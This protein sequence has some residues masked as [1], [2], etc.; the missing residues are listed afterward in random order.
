MPQHSNPELEQYESIWHEALRFVCEQQGADY[1]YFEGS[2]LLRSNIQPEHVVIDGYPQGWRQHYLDN[3]YA[4]IDPAVAHTQSHLSPFVWPTEVD[5]FARLSRAQKKMYADAKNFGIESGIS[6]TYR[7]VSAQHGTLH[8]ASEQ[9][10]AKSPLSD[11]AV[12]YEF[13]MLGTMLM[14]SHLEQHG[15][16]IAEL[17]KSLTPRETECLRWVAEG[18]TSEE[19]ADIIGISQRT[20]VFHLQNAMEK[21]GTHSRTSAA[22]KY[23]LYSIEK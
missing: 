11:K 16:A 10:L 23:A 8:I 1:Y 3:D 21:M 19:I 18:K 2:L 7:G 6:F 5:D 20:V 13:F 4:K 22:V 14:D 17:K 15:K 12:Q 9:T